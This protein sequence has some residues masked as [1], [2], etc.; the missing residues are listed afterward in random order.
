MIEINEKEM[1][2]SLIMLI[3]R[4]P[5][6]NENSKKKKLVQFLERKPYKLS[7]KC[8]QKPYKLLLNKEIVWFCGTKI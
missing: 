1:R 5:K 3:L 8:V 4:L 7:K 6:I 2:F